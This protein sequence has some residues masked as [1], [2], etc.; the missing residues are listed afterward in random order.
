MPYEK[1]ETDKDYAPGNWWTCWVCGANITGPLGEPII[2]RR[3]GKH[4]HERCGGPPAPDRPPVSHAEVRAKAEAN[5][6]KR[7][8]T[9]SGPGGR[10]IRSPRG[11]S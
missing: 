3:D 4:R 11:L 8:G 10:V 1:Y 5:R 9:G 7:H 2:V 6:D